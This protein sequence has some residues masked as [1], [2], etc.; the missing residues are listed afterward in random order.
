M[1]LNAFLD[2]PSMVS[3]GLWRRGA[4][5]REAEQRENAGKRARKPTTVL[6]GHYQ[7]YSNKFHIPQVSSS[8]VE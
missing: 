2:V 7:R 8:W 1:P 5:K 4:I 6:I 3:M